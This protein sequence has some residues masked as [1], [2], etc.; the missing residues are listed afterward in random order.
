MSTKYKAPSS[1]YKDQRPKTQVQSLCD[2]FPQLL[3]KTLWIFWCNASIKLLLLGFLQNAHSSGVSVNS[4]QT[5]VCMHETESLTGKSSAPFAADCSCASRDQ[6]ERLHQVTAKR[7]ERNWSSD[8]GGVKPVSEVLN[9]R[10]AARDILASALESVDAGKAVKEAVQLQDSR[11]TL[12]NTTVN[13]NSPDSK[14]YVI[15][16]GKAALSMAASLNDLLGD[17][18]IG[19]VVSGP[20]PEPGAGGSFLDSHRWQFF[21]GGHP[22]PNQPSLD[23]AKA[24]FDLLADADRARGVVVFLVSG[25]G[26]AMLESPADDQISLAD[27]IEGNRL[28][29]TCGAGITEINA[30]RRAISAVKGGRLAARAPNT[31]QISLIISDTNAGDEASVAS[32]P[33]IEPPL[34]APEPQAVLAR[35]QTLADLPDSVLKAITSAAPLSR[36]S[37][38]T[39]QSRNHVVL[40]DNRCA[41]EAADREARRLGFISEVAFDLVELNIEEGC[42]ALL[43]RLS[44]LRAKSA[45]P[46]QPVCLISGGEFLCPVRGNGVGGRNAETVLRCAI[47]IDRQSRNLS[48]ERETLILS[49]GTDGIDGNSPAAGAIADRSTLRRARSLGLDAGSFLNNSD[50]FS[51]FDRLGDTIVTGAT[52]TN[53]RDVRILLSS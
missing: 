48:D 14:L 11:C 40:L 18:I 22:L 23:A 27:L 13:L 29:V 43:S 44:A 32:G 41:L 10:Q 36:A 31:T 19:G 4:S 33:T 15:A 30:V 28:L 24:C 17:W 12:A 21:A 38:S 42:H 49:A 1:K 9:L 8:F 50:A 26:S 7:N 20:V 47:K 46:G 6:H 5:L 16:A 53:V 34:H 35:Y 2:K 51:F 45:G 37:P 39:K 25:G 52:G 3:W